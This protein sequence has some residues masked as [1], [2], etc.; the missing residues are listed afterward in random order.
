MKYINNN[1]C[2]QKSSLLLPRKP[3]SPPSANRP[4]DHLAPG[5]LACTS[6]DI[7][8]SSSNS[9]H[10]YASVANRGIHTSH[11][12]ETLELDLRGRSTYSN[13]SKRSNRSH[14]PGYESSTYLL[15]LCFESCLYPYHDTKQWYPERMQCSFQESKNGIED[16]KVY[17]HKLA[18]HS[19]DTVIMYTE[20]SP[21][22]SCK[23]P[24]TKHFRL[25]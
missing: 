15:Q 22:S 19:R 14:F 18:L 2:K 25:S 13:R 7:P 10:E 11:I 24:Q 17:V 21:N 5:T 6:I 4:K 9:S 23:Y 12:I 8:R 16:D 20:I 3:E 1:P